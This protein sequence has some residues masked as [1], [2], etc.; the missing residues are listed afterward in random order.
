MQAL[1]RRTVRDARHLQTNQVEM[2]RKS[3]KPQVAEY[4]RE[5]ENREASFNGNIC[6]ANVSGCGNPYRAESA[7]SRRASK[8]EREFRRESSSHGECERRDTMT[9]FIPTVPPRREYAFETVV[10]RRPALFQNLLCV[11]KL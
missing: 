11:R 2:V 6:H 7:G 8:I 9:L 3:G 4:T 5:K 1:L 10:R